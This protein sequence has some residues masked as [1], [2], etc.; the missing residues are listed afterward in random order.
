LK[1]IEN[2]DGVTGIFIDIIFPTAL[3]LWSRLSL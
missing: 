2:S 1:Y 3:G